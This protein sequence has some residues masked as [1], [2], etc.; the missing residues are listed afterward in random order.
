MEEIFV[1]LMCKCQSRRAKYKPHILKTA[2]QILS[3][4]DPGKNY[5][6]TTFVYQR[7]QGCTVAMVM[8]AGS[9]SAKLM[10]YSPFQETIFR[11]GPYL[12]VCFLGSADQGLSQWNTV[13]GLTPVSTTRMNLNVNINK[14]YFRCIEKKVH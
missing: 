4:K 3:S 11:I 1:G 5:R 13:C 8:S 12:T 7:R 10:D 9:Y 6:I 2:T 14:M